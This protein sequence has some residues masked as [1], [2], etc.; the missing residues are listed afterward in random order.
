MQLPQLFSHVALLQHIKYCMWPAF[1]NYSK[2][3]RSSKQTAQRCLNDI[4]KQRELH[5]FYVWGTRTECQV[6]RQHSGCWCISSCHILTCPKV[7]LWA[8]CPAKSSTICSLFNFFSYY[9]QSSKPLC[10]LSR[11]FPLH[12]MRLF[13]HNCDRNGQKRQ[14]S[15]THLIEGRTSAGGS[16]MT[17]LA[18]IMQ[19]NP[20]CT[21]W[22][23][24]ILGGL[25]LCHWVHA[26]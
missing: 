4:V 6:V 24:N 17:I 1:L 22:S 3:I 7:S 18:L 25:D 15:L 11:S 10:P 21:C 26:G 12:W 5:V 9:T 2:T 16:N 13:S 14:K 23:W 20:A 8:L 19:P